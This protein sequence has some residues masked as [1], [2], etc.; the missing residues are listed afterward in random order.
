ME[1]FIFC[2]VK[3]TSLVN[4]VNYVSVIRILTAFIT[5][6][7]TFQL[8]RKS[9][10]LCLKLAFFTGCFECTFHLK[11][12]FYVYFEETQLANTKY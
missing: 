2:V 11:K 10:H 7:A 3:E 6:I 5:E 8:V 4:V 9:F 12:I 1:N